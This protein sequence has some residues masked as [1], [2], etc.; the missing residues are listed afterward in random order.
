M[1]SPSDGAVQLGQ[2]IVTNPCK[3]QWVSVKPKQLTLS[4]VLKPWM[5]IR[6]DRKD[7]YHI[8]CRINA[9]QNQSLI[10]N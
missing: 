6:L 10:P 2:S 3:M 5:R 1:F 8:K 4:R 9:S 7:L